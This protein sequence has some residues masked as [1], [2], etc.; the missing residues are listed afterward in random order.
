MKKFIFSPS[1]VLFWCCIIGSLVVRDILFVFI[2]VCFLGIYVFSLIDSVNK[3]KK[4]FVA[5]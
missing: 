3:S 1:L 2:G 4:A 5:K